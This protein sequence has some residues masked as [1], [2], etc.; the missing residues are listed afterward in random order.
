M[1]TRCR[2]PT[3]KAYPDYG[4]R[5]IVVYK[6]WETYLAFKTGALASGYDETL[7]IDRKNVNKGYN[8]DNCQWVL[9]IHRNRN[10]RK[11]SNC[12]SKYIGVSKHTRYP[13]L[14]ICQIKGRP[15]GK[16]SFVGHFMDEVE[17]A[18][19][20]DRVCKEEFGFVV[21]PNFPEECD[22]EET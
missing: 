6:E 8:P 7:E 2:C 5:G 14:W 10:K 17:A 1:L 15:N 9:P 16:S 13:H 3:D 19:A 22:E 18:K 21:N 20:Y 11:R 12:T 4:G